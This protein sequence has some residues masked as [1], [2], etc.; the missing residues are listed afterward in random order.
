TRHFAR[1]RRR[2]MDLLIG[3]TVDAEVLISTAVAAASGS[4]GAVVHTGLGDA[5]AR[6]PIERHRTVLVAQRLQ[7]EKS[8]EV[9]LR[10]FALSGLADA[11]WC[12]RIAGSGPE[13]SALE[14]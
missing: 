11:G 1:A 10:A 13:R 4:R 6:T 9:A 2:G 5:P 14:Q 3:T 12:M 8:T 7:P